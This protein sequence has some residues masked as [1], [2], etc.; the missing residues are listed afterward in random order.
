[1]SLLTRTFSRRGSCCLL[2]KHANALCLVCWV[3]SDIANIKNNIN[4]K[5][6]LLFLCVQYDGLC[7]VKNTM[8]KVNYCRILHVQTFIK[9]IDT[10]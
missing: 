8:V 1:M 9:H 10:K 2:N 4:K 3:K 7:S 5:H 6:K